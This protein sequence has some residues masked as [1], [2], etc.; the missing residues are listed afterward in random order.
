MMDYPKLYKATFRIQS[1]ATLLNKSGQ[2]DAWD[3]W[4]VRDIAP[5]SDKDGSWIRD[6][7]KILLFYS[8][9]S[10]KSKGQIQQSGMAHFCEET[11]SCRR[12]SGNPFVE[13]GKF[14]YC[15][16]ILTTPWITK[17]SSSS[18]VG[19]F[20]A[21]EKVGSNE[22]IVIRVAS[23]LDDFQKLPD[24]PSLNVSDLIGLRRKPS[25]MGVL[26]ICH[27]ESNY[28]VAFEGYEAT[29]EN[30]GQIFGVYTSDWKTFTPANDGQPLFS[31]REVRSWPVKAVCNPRF[32]KLE[33]GWFALAFNGSHGGEY[34][35]GL[36]FTKDF[37]K[38]IEH[39]QNPILV[40]RGW[41]ESDPMTGRLEGP[42]FDRDAILG[43]NQ[44]A[45]MFFM[46]IPYGA[47]NHENAINAMITFEITQELPIKEKIK[48]FPKN[49]EALRFSDD[50]FFL[51]GS[52]EESGYLHAHSIQSEGIKSITLNFEQVRFYGDDSSIF[53]VVSNT[54]N[55]LPRGIGQ[56]IKINNC[57]IFLFQERLQ[58]HTPRAS[59]YL[60]K[61][62]SHRVLKLFYRYFSKLEDT[63]APQL[64]WKRIAQRGADVMRVEGNYTIEFSD[65]AKIGRGFF[66][67]ANGKHVNQNRIIL[68]NRDYRILTIAVFKTDLRISGLN[69][70]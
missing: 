44:V 21:A 62:I 5:L 24:V 25:L 4:G 52:K 33:D 29:H 20:R 59:Y 70:T 26:N 57:G 53:I 30:K 15:Q 37:R 35:I 42:C 11:N 36:A 2:P 65:D 64:G 41:P 58:Q 18:F 46:A 3:S 67:P 49:P 28:L 55:S 12:I 10:K 6:N 51:L 48:T 8:G 7:G 27:L 32:I 22:S 54:L 34:S 31:C 14:P 56:I 16:N 66:V 40:P 38:W 17:L 45:K 63:F 68:Q 23:C 1:C 19:A 50:G 69:I 47:R 13:S 43:G 61:K 39:P 9:S 60:F